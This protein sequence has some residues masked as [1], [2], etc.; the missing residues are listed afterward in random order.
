[1]TG[2]AGTKVVVL[3]DYQDV[4]RHFGPWEQ[5]ADAIELTVVGDHIADT[6]ELL[7]R[8][9]G[10]HVIVA[11][12]ERT[13]FDRQ[14]LE[15]LTDLRLLVTTGM[16]NTAIDMEA[17]KDLGITVCGTASPPGPPAELTWALI[18]AITRN[19]CRE[20]QAVRAGGWQHTIGPELEGRTLG[21]IG[22][23]R[24]GS[25]V[26]AFGKAFGMRLLAWSTNLDPAA[27]AAVGAEAVSK[28]TLL[29]DADVVTLHLRLSDR[30]RGIIGAAD[31]ATMRPTAYLVNTSRGPLIDE[32]A[33]V[34]ALRAG[35][36]A[37]AGLDVFE[38]EP[39]PLNHPLRCMPNVVV[40][41]HLGYVSTGSY[42]TYYREAVEDIAAWLAGSPVRVL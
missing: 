33:L 16:A 3:D 19:V 36:I 22:M 4:A 28:Q 21:V 24:L 15:R 18:L 9:A 25:R 40:T 13:P 37:G 1:M 39:L 38:T 29:A 10:A 23:G 34:Q 30:T 20:D 12:R 14:R 26:A 7:A 27:A 2:A 6:E 35:Q 11:M 42:A 5:L 17:A 41:P 8:L 32:Q 31:L